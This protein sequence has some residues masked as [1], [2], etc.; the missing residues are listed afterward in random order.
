MGIGDHGNGDVVLER[1]QQLH[2]QRGLAR[3][4]FA[5]D[6][7]NRRT[8]YQPVFQRGIGAAVLGRPKQKIRIRHQRK[9]TLQQPEI[10][11]IDV[12]GSNCTHTKNITVTPYKIPRVPFHPCVVVPVQPWLQGFIVPWFRPRAAADQTR[13]GSGELTSAF[14][15]A[16]RSFAACRSQRVVPECRSQPAASTPQSHNAVPARNPG[17]QPRTTG[18]VAQARPAD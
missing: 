6:Q 13:T 16:D 12:D 15:V 17:Q 7:C 2:Q 9:R 1:A 10:V 3:A 4:H 8:R 14:A 18:H 11:G 5:G